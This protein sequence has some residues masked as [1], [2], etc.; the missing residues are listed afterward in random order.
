MGESIR[1]TIQVEL[2]RYNSHW[3]RIRVQFGLELLLHVAKQ[4]KYERVRKTGET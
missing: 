4:A 2:G 3:R 1:I